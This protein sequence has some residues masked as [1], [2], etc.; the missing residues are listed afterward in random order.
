MDSFFCNPE[1]LKIS[2]VFLRFQKKILVDLEVELK[3]VLTT[4]SSSTH[5]GV[6][7]AD[8]LILCG[9]QPEFSNYVMF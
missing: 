4:C 8:V 5:I 9:S 6:D 7:T 2:D 1:D 3:E